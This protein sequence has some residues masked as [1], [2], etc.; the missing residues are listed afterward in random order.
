MAISRAHT[1]DES[2]VGAGLSLVNRSTDSVT[3]E[4][5][6]VDLMLSLMVTA[7]SV[8]AGEGSSISRHC[9]VHGVSRS[10]PFR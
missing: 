7:G 1:P 4:S 2:P 3:G 5:R 6:S 9:Q 8:N 10:R